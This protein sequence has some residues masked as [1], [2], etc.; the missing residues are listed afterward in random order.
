MDTTTNPKTLFEVTPPTHSTAPHPVTSLD[1]YITRSHYDRATIR[2]PEGKAPGPDA[3][4]NELIK[5]LSE[6]THILLYNLFRI[7]AKYNCTPKKLCRS[8]TCLLYKPNKKDP[9]NIAYCRLIALVNDVLKI[10]SSILTSIGSPWAEA[11]GI[12]SDTIDGFRRHRKIYDS[13]STHIMMY[14]DAKM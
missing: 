6:A 13:M 14:E 3:M 5:H 11:Q 1:S 4:T 2:A 7:M 12:L 8:A 9:H 10:W